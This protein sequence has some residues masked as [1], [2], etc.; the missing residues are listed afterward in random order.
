MALTAWPEQ[1][2]EVADTVNDD[3]TVAPFDGLLTLIPSVETAA[4]SA[5]DAVDE[6]VTSIATSVTQEA[7]LSP[8]DFTWSVW[9]PVAAETLASIEVP[10]TTVVLE[11]LSSE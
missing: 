9:F 11:L 7:P 3:E 8:Q 6:P 1:L 5:A 2:V 4:S 10:S